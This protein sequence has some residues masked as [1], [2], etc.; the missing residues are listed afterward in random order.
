[1]SQTER[2]KQIIK[3]WASESKIDYRKNNMF[4]DVDTYFTTINTNGIS[5]S[6]YDFNNIPQLEKLFNELWTIERDDSVPRICAIAAFKERIK[7]DDMK[8]MRNKD[9][10]RVLPEFIYNM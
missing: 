3:M 1:M 5:V 10:D 7:Y 6:E 4:K 2:E 9:S 8:D